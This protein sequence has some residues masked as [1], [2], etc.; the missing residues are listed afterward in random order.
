MWRRWLCFGFV[1]V[2]SF[3]QSAAA[4]PSAEE[5]SSLGGLA[6]PP[7]LPWSGTPEG[8]VVAEDD[9]WITPCEE[10]GLE[11]SPDYDATIRWLD[12]L[13]A[14]TPD[15]ER[16]DVGRTHEGR[17][18]VMIVASRGG[19]R[20]ASELASN[21]RP[22]LL[23]HAGIHAGE[24]DGKDAGMMILRDLTVGGRDDVLDRVNL[25]FIP[26]LNPDGH[27]RRS[28]YSRINQR[29]PSEMGWR[30]NARNQNLNRDFA[31]LDTPEV[32]ALID[33]INDWEPLLYVDLHVTDGIDYQYDITWGYNGAHAWS[34][35]IAGW[36]DDALTP[37]VSEALEAEAHVPGP[38]IFAI[39][40]ADP[41]RGVFG[42]TA[43]PRFS[44]GYGDARH[45]ATILVEN[46]SLKPYPQRVLGTYT[47][48]RSALHAFADGYRALEAATEEDRARRLEDV[49][50]SWRA[51]DGEP[52][53]V[54]FLG[55]EFEVRRS[56]I[57]GGLVTD[58]LGRP[59][60]TTV[61]R[62]VPTE[63]D[64]SV[65]RA[66]AYWVPATWGEVIDR[67]EGHGVEVE[68]TDR[69]IERELEFYRLADP[70][71]DEAPFEGRMR[72]R[73]DTETTRIVRQLPPGSVRVSTDQ[74]LGTLATLLLEPGS[75]DSFFQWGFLL[76]I[77]QR[78]EY[79]EAYAMEPFAQ[80]MLDESAELRDEFHQKLRGDREFS[81]DPRARLQWFYERTPFF[82][83][84]WRVYPIGREVA[85]EQ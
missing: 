9:P 71:Y 73:A 29:G 36:L 42:W 63:P 12:R 35:A 54:D 72:V 66:K 46:H 47:F 51:P 64:L 8:R 3:A 80:K 40:R 15:L 74:A 45:L 25:L 85:I 56:S 75:P 41:D 26:V 13:V 28:P 65:K 61:P 43:G 53:E 37:R 5:T 60:E 68:R 76:E 38:L 78:T 77:M 4:D 49:P 18:I 21:G 83:A 55:V 70:T 27:E 32:R 84:E 58:W 81:S 44:N 14:A 48:L 20:S 17:E 19:A 79:A 23:A 52:A 33:V 50:L 11:A 57:T 2:L 69:W 22:T 31:K 34:P 6:L 59:R 10:A 62:V 67:L 82:D 1:S 39:D 30:T 16:V 7:V 24:I